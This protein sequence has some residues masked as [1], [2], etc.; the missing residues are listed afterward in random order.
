M[1]LLRSACNPQNRRNFENMS[2]C[3]YHA[4]FEEK[5]DYLD[6][7]LYLFPRYYVSKHQFYTFNIGNNV[8]KIYKL[9]P[10]LQKHILDPLLLISPQNTDVAHVVQFIRP[11]AK[12]LFECDFELVV[13]FFQTLETRISKNKA[14][15]GVKLEG[16][17]L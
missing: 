17:R 4:P 6:E 7:T 1:L 15:H 8:L 3:V 13:S 14:N 11:R 2:S 16:K 12:T 5:W 9:P 10:P